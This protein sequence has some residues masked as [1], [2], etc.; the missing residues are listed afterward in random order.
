MRPYTSRNN[1]VVRLHTV[2]PQSSVADVDWVYHLGPGVHVGNCAYPRDCVALAQPWNFFR[3]AKDV[4]PNFN[5]SIVPTT[6]WI[7]VSKPNSRMESY[8]ADAS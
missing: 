6:V 2:F 4:T 7:R 8:E 1:S 5:P 3:S